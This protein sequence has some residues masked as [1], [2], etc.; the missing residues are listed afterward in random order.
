M[1]TKKYKHYTY[2]GSER[3][4]RHKGS[5]RFLGARGSAVAR[6]SRDKSAAAEAT[7]EKQNG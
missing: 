4:F 6:L 7:A 5:E 2:T 1:T 3:F